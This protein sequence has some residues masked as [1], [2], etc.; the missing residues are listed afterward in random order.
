[1]PASNVQWPVPLTRLHPW[2]PGQFG[3]PGTDSDRGLRQ[4]SNGKVIWVDP[5][6]ADAHDGKDGTDP[7]SPMATVAGALTKCRAYSGDV[8]VVAFN[9]LWTYANTGAGLRILPVQ[10]SV[11]VTVPGV[12]IVGLSASGLGVYWYPASN[13]GVCITVHAIDVTIEGFVFSEGPTFAGCTA[14]YAEW[15]GATLFGENLTVRHCTFDDTVDI[16]VQLEYSWYCDIHS[17]H[18]LQCDGYGVYTAAAGS[19]TAYSV[20]HDNWFTDCGTAAIALLGGADDNSIYNN[21]IYNANA[22]AG[23]LATNEGINTTGGANNMVMNNWLSCLLP[24]GANGDLDDL[25]TAAATDAWAGNFC[26]N[27]LQITQ[28]T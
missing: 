15:D 14:I 27:G 26:M 7:D 16:A 12:R 2:Y 18:F 5:N 28:P 20:I 11:V 24:A 22:Q 25:N 1:M 6:H 8:I 13:A 4:D 23:A 21:R 17:N 9:G 10:E 3:V 19:G